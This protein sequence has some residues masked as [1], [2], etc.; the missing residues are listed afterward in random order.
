MSSDLPYID[1]NLFNEKVA[2]FAKTNSLLKGLFNHPHSKI[3][4]WEQLPAHLIQDL[5]TRLGC[6]PSIQKY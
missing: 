4:T 2:E 5:F 3:K 6:K 1:A